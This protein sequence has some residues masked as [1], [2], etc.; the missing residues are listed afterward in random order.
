MNWTELSLGRAE[1]RPIQT[2]PSQARLNYIKQIQQIHNT[3]Y[4]NR[5]SSQL[6]QILFSDAIELDNV[7]LKFGRRILVS[8][9]LL[10]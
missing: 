2:Q 3:F 6:E 9:Q 4:C 5:I 8:M 10:Y 1:L 7:T